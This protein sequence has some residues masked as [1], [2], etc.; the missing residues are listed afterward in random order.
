MNREP[1]AAATAETRAALGLFAVV[2]GVH[3]WCAHLGWHNVPVDGHEFRQTQTA[4]SVRYLVQ[5]GLRLDYPT[6]LLGK[7][8][9]IPLEFPLYQDAV[10]LLVRTT[11]RPIPEAGRTVG[12]LFFYLTLPGIYLLAGRL[13]LPPARRLLIL[14]AI[15]TSPLFLFYTRTVMIETTVLCLCTWFLCA[16]WRAVAGGDWLAAVTAMGCGALAAMVKLPTLVVFLL[17]AALIL[18]RETRRP[19][20]EKTGGGSWWRKP[21]TALAVI[22]VALG[23]GLA[24]TAHAD[25]VK[26]LNPLASFLNSTA[27]GVWGM[28]PVSLRFSSAFWTSISFNTSHAVLG[29]TGLIVVGIFSCLPSR[30][31][32]RKIWLLLACFVPGPLIFANLYQLHDYY[33]L[34]PAIFLLAAF[35][36]ALGCVLDLPRLP[37][38]A[39]WLLVTGLLSLGVVTYARTYYRLIPDNESRV[40]QLSRALKA[41]TR[42]DDV[43]VIFGQDWNPVLPYTAERRALMIP[44]GMEKNPVAW[45]DAFTRLGPAR[46]GAL[47]VT[48][49]MREHRDRLQPVISRFDLAVQPLLTGNNTEVYLREADTPANVTALLSLG[50]SEYQ[51]ETRGLPVE[52]DRLGDQ[53]RKFFAMMTPRPRAVAAQF[54]LGLLSLDDG[55][56]FGAHP[57]TQ[58]VFTMP[59]GARRLRAGFGVLPGAYADPRKGTDGVVFQVRLREADGTTRTL[60]E[61]LLEP[62][63][64]EKD[65]GTQTFD[66]ALPAGVAGDIILQTGPGPANNFAFDWAYWSSVA[67]E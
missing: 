55:V 46:V 47:V 15:L 4:I 34:A 6:P 60:A 28:G 12:L 22:G 51:V 20:A 19:P 37:R 23:A 27:V 42:P 18:F 35:G 58:L 49:P 17:P 30:P 62:V 50:L 64:R 24:W 29:Y 13:A 16:Y 26:A 67:I 38:P 2:L 57:I 25:A 36:L 8:W 21:A 66:L 43:L 53:A 11:G 56:V 48:G 65:R 54:G 5:D 3:L 39:G 7:P 1:T 41:A 33:F 32:R 40:P 63:T 52:V 14:A 31:G 44:P 45:A 59:P 9:S 61:R 10:A